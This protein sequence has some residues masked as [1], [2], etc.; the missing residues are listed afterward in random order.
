[1]SSTTTL[2]WHTVPSAE[3]QTT[4]LMGKVITSRVAEGRYPGWL[5]ALNKVRHDLSGDV[6][7][8]AWFS[9]VKTQTEHRLAL[10]NFNQVRAAAIKHHNHA[11]Y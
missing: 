6:I 8:E 1:M 11:G 5:Y 7:W 9:D 10:G 3:G 4:K 2:E